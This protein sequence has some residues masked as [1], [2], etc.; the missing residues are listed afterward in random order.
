M[1]QRGRGPSF[2]TLVK[3]L[4]VMGQRSQMFA[5]V[6]QHGAFITE[7]PVRIG[8]HYQ[9]VWGEHMII[10]AGQVIRYLD[11][12]TQNG[13]LRYSSAAEIAAGITATYGV[14]QATG[15][16]QGLSSRDDV[17]DF[18]LTGCD[19]NDGAFLVHVSKEREYSFGFVLNTG[20]QDFSPLCGVQA[21]IDCYRV[22]RPSPEVQEAITALQAAA[23]RGRLMDA[24]TD[25][26]VAT[27]PNS[28]SIKSPRWLGASVHE[29]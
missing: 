1:C 22:H 23:E 3:G 24:E 17:S 7:K 5:V 10:R 21:V 18:S 29:R 2:E 20:Y 27:A 16:V 28:T 6:E 8:R 4:S 15:E 19:N 14:N 13:A 12:A 11:T 9:W 26:L 25:F